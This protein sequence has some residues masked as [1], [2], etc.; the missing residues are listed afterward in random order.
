ME[1]YIMSYK[2]TKKYYGRWAG[3]EV[4]LKTYIA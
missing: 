3:V 2:T 1:F 4:Q